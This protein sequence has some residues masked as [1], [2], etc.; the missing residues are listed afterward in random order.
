MMLIDLHAKSNLSPEVNLSIDEVL[1]KAK[2]TGLDAVAFT[3]ALSSAQ[4]QHAI[5]AGKRKGV[6][7]FIGVEMHTDKG[8]VVGFLPQIDSYYLNEEWRELTDYTTPAIEDVIAEFASR[9]GAVLATRPYDLDIP[10]NMG[11]MIFT[12]EN[13]CGV[14][15]FNA[16]VGELQNDFALEASRFMGLPT[17]GGSDPRG[18]A[19]GLGAFA[20]LFLEDLETQSDFVAALLKKEFWAIQLGDIKL[21]STTLASDVYD[22]R[23]QRDDDRRG[24]GDR[25]RGGSGGGG[26]GGRR[27]NDRSD[28]RGR[29]SSRDKDN[30]G[31]DSRRRSGGRGKKGGGDSS[32]S[33]RGR[34]R[35]RSSSRRNSDRSSKN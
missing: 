18:E 31:D 30:G 13:L 6:K 34:G 25:R 24:G 26:G 9:G 10:Y 19:R 28:S 35:G 16:N 3:E 29:S 32:S 7:V 1:D 20:T 2:S 5:E 27:G 21:K 8:I 22:K 12:V 23:E 33:G 4:C 11:D 14:E 17:M 15:V